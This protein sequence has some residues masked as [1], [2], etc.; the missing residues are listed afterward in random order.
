MSQLSNPI[1]RLVLSYIT[2]EIK[3]VLKVK[4]KFKNLK[5]LREIMNFPKEWLGHKFLNKR[6]YNN[7]KMMKW[8][9]NNFEFT[10]NEII[11]CFI[12]CCNLVRGNKVRFIINNFTINREEFMYWK[13]TLYIN[14]TPYSQYLLNWLR[15]QFELTTKED[16]KFRYNWKGYNK[17]ELY[18]SKHYSRYQKLT[19][20]DPFE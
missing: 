1:Q 14:H 12:D 8:T 15:E 6:I 17:W 13:N 4:T 19:F 10:Q 2:D 3:N 5:W 20:Y 9:L 18:G 16:D 7:F 11:C